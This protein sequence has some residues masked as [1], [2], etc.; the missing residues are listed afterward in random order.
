MIEVYRFLA[1]TV[2]KMT[3]GLLNPKSS[4]KNAIFFS[5]MMIFVC[6]PTYAMGCFV[7]WQF[8]FFSQ[9]VRVFWG[10]VLS[11]QVEGTSEKK[12]CTS[13]VAR[14]FLVYG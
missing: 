9:V 12:W 8:L 7:R 6:V 5:C 10:E 13:V 1:K 4:G 3:G 11:S 14:V 2:S